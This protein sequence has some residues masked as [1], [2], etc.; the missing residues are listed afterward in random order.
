M[1]PH[2]KLLIT[3]LLIL[4]AV[5]LLF[6]L[7]TPTTSS[8]TTITVDDD[9]GGE[10]DYTTIQDAIN[11]SENGDTIRVYNGVYNERLIVD[12]SVSLVGDGK[13][14]TIIDGQEKG[15][16]VV[17][18][19]EWVNVSGFGVTGSG[20][21]FSG[22]RV[23]ANH[24]TLSENNITWCGIA[25]YLNGSSHNFLTNTN[26][27]NTGYAVYL[28]SATR[29]TITNANSMSCVYGIW[30][31]G[32]SNNN[33]LTSN[34][35]SGT[36][37]AIHS[38]A[39]DTILMDNHCESNGYG[40]YL[41]SAYSAIL[42]GNSCV[43]SFSAAIWLFN[44][45]H[46]ILENNTI[47]TGSEFGIRIANSGHCVLENNTVRNIS[48]YGIMVS[49]S[50]SSVLTNNRCSDS[51]YL[52]ISLFSS[53]GSTIRGN[54][55]SNT[56]LSGIYIGSSDNCR[57][58]GNS[59]TNTS[60][61]AISLHGSGGSVC[62]GNTISDMDGNGFTISSTN[63]SFVNNTMTKGGIRI[64]GESTGYWNTHSIDTTNTVNGKSI[65]YYKDQRG[66]VVPTDAGQLILANCTDMTIENLNFANVSTGLALGFSSYIEIVNSSFS[67]CSSA[68]IS[69]MYSDN[70]TITENTFLDCSYGSSLQDSNNNII[71]ENSFLN[72]IYGLSLSSSR[73]TSITG[74]TITGNS[75]GITVRAISTGSRIH[76]NIIS[77]NEDYGLYANYSQGAVE[78]SYNWW[79]DESG[80]HYASLNPTGK[81]DPVT[82]NVN[83]TYWLRK[84]NDEPQILGVYT[85]TLEDAWEYQAHFATLNMNESTLEWSMKT[86][87]SF[88]SFDRTRAVL[89][90]TPTREGPYWV[91]V[92]ADDGNVADTYNFTLSVF[93]VDDVPV[94]TID[95]IT[96]QPV[97]GKVNITGTI[98]DEEGKIEKVQVSIKGSFSYQNAV[99][100]NGS[101][102]YFV[103]D[104]SDYENGNHT[105]H[106]RAFDG[107]HYSETATTITI[108]NPAEEK[109]YDSVVGV[110]FGLGLLVF[111]VG[112]VG[113][114]FFSAYKM[115]DRKPGEKGTKKSIFMGD[116]MRRKDFHRER[117]ALAAWKEQED[118]VEGDDG[119]KEVEDEGVSKGEDGAGAGDDGEPSVIKDDGEGKTEE[120]S[121]DT[122]KDEAPEEPPKQEETDVSEKSPE[123]EEPGE[124]EDSIH[125]YIRTLKP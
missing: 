35:C 33:T 47:Q 38:E 43:D 5:L 77:G 90:G 53:P 113:Y 102:W 41:D 69:L 23:Q 120:K 86:N 99:V 12:K 96:E 7:T 63:V 68:G 123:R 17:I 83:F 125:S 89:N 85:G 116:G 71:S 42:T 76:Y 115:R 124:K 66:G 60:Y 94:V 25:V 4:T 20:D 30:L 95:S 82:H 111:T 101:R 91:E 48:I 8:A 67:S 117:R 59:C 29:N 28:R 40:I 1:P 46:S 10:A 105:I 49:S 31:D 74:N 110:V 45:S 81:G 80:P 44:S 62:S 93:P 36:M 118:V 54:T 16:V 6:T 92:A 9:S 55:V 121:E 97:K 108:D 122:E 73:Y 70:N 84:D 79:G 11:S 37:R 87:A 72:G 104:S 57:I 26:F 98:Y 14:E 19:A 103:F 15:D 18:S 109:E 32:Q 114:L 21:A 22:L 39:A 107:N 106:V 58:S 64:Y 34:S 112:F 75:A 50:N 56:G 51:E 65:Y 13:E 3:I 27:S 100:V 119:E 2:T 88:L 78:A 24:S 52:G 61:T